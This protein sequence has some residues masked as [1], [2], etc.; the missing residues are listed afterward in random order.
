MHGREAYERG[1][2]RHLQGAYLDCDEINSTVAAA[3]ADGEDLE[4]FF[5]DFSEVEALSLTGK[6][7]WHDQVYQDRW[8]YWWWSNIITGWGLTQPMP[9]DLQSEAGLK[10]AGQHM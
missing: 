6:N 4:K 7:A 2:P 3:L 1:A 8:R 5:C 9:A 10:S